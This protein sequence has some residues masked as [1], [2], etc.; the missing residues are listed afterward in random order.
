MDSF[1][2][3]VDVLQAAQDLR[4][5]TLAG[6]PRS[7]DRL[8]YL[9]ST[10]DYNTGLYYHDGLASRFTPEVACEALANC[11]FEVF[12]QLVLC[13][14]ED[15]V[16]QLEAYVRSTHANPVEVVAAWRKLEPFRVAV[17]LDTDPLSSEFLNS[18][19]RTALAILEARWKSLPTES[20]ASPRPLP[21]R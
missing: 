1:P 8:V 10:R 5:R 17:P 18:G 6:M 15:L 11:H 2:K 19:L 9:A 16:A 21:A 3:R 14:L 7:L 12:R 4:D 20:A 13:P